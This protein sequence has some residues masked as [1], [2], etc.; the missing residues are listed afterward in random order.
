MHTVRVK[1]TQ[2]MYH[3]GTWR[4][5]CACPAKPSIG[6]P[7][8][9]SIGCP[10]DPSIV[11]H[12][13]PSIMCPPEPSIVCPPLNCVPR[14]PLN[15]VPSWPLNCVPCWPLSCVLHTIAV[16]QL[17]WTG[18]CDTILES[19]PSFLWCRS[20]MLSK[21]AAGLKPKQ[22]SADLWRVRQK[23]VP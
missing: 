6:C 1:A 21:R 7:P 14:W 3:S 17:F 4:T 19:A 9:P 22:K 10:A 23:K 20:L 12:P 16:P 13:E 5:Q 18:K 15:C 11:C 8:E 2:E